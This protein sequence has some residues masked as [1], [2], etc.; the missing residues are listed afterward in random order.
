MKYSPRKQISCLLLSAVFFNSC[1]GQVK[2]NFPEGKVTANSKQTKIPKAHNTF[3]GAS[4]GCAVQDQKGIIW[5]GTNG[6]GVFRYDGEIFTNYTSKDGLDN[7]IVC[8]ILVDKAG[9][10]WVGT[11]TGLNRYDGKAFATVPIDVNDSRSFLSDNSSGNNPPPK[12]GVWSMMQDK[13]GMIWFGTDAGVYRYD[14][15]SFSRFLD[16]TNIGNRDS[17]GLKAVF[18]MLED[19][20][21]NIWFGT[22][23]AEGISR[24]DGKSLINIVPQKDVGRVNRIIED[25]KGKMWFTTTLN[26]VCCYD[27]KTFIKNVFDK[28][29]GDKD[30]ILQ[31]KAGT[32]WFDTK[33]GPGCYD[34]KTLKILTGKDGLPEKKIYPVLADGHNNI[35]FSAERMGLYKWDGKTFT[36]FSEH[37][38]NH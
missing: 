12:N 32:I 33:D 27:G 10:I 16:N 25:R 23:V 9:N 7:N 6:E 15:S 21:G 11:Q 37:R 26:Y 17:L 19:E 31:D 2:N 34:G 5:F 29:D 35:W 24:F 38:A 14:G 30:L 1:N 22:C 36:D 4:V 13:R 28:K 8:S 20:K 18:S 3:T